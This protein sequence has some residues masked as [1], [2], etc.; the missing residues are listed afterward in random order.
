MS[1]PRRRIHHHFFAF[2][3]GRTCSH[4]ERKCAPVST[5]LPRWSLHKRSPVLALVQLSTSTNVNVRRRSHPRASTRRPFRS[6]GLFV[7]GTR[8]DAKTSDSERALRARTPSAHSE[9]AL[10]VLQLPPLRQLP[11]RPFL[12]RYILGFHCCLTGSPSVVA[13]VSVCDRVEI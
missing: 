10:R 7:S 9:R 4:T 8:R 3:R 1:F 12:V 11:P 6:C 5:P 2:P 13:L